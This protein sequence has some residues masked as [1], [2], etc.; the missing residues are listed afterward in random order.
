MP[1]CRWGA[2]SGGAIR[3]RGRQRQRDARPARPNRARL[4][5]QVTVTIGRPPGY[6][7]MTLGEVRAHFRR[8]LDERVAQI[9]A[10]RRAQGRIHVLGVAA[11]LAQD[12]LAALV[13]DTFPTF[14]LNPR[15]SGSGQVF[16]ALRR[17]L[18]AWRARYRAAYASWRAGDRQV[19]FPLGSYA[20][21]RFHGA[22]VERATGP[23][24]LF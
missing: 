6:E 1:A 7:H 21:P 19:V 4:P 20:L 9:H 12:P 24:A 14:K 22:R 3:T 5:E 13:E 23:P 18:R 2:P 17:G 15:L 16:C 8:L 11:I 10:E